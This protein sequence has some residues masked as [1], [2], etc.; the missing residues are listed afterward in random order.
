LQVS[1]KAVLFFV[2]GGLSDIVKGR[3]DPGVIVVDE[4][5]RIVYLNEEAARIFPDLSELPEKIGDICDC[6]K[7]KAKT[8]MTGDP[9]EQP[10]AILPR[11]PEGTL[12]ARAFFLN[13]REEATQR[14]LVLLE[15][16][17]E[18][19]TIN[20]DRTGLDFNFTRRER[21]VLALLNEGCSNREIAGQLYITEQT[22]KDHLRHIMRKMGVTS[23]SAVLA[24]LR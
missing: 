13:G 17:T 3:G 11:G 20:I 9:A 23:R 16:I 4:K 8:G 15:R 2:V 6:L 24:R 22:V 19:R 21:E 12:S 1:K 7:K 14:I 5:N 18:R 10:F